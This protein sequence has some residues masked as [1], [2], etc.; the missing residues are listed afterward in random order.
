MATKAE[1]S[2]YRAERSGP[3]KPKQ[4]EPPRRDVPVDTAQPGTSATYRKARPTRT[5][6]A[7]RKG[8]AVVEESSRKSTRRSHGKVET[9]SFNEAGVESK[10]KGEGRTKRSANLQLR[11]VARVRAPSARTQ[12]KI[13]GGG[14]KLP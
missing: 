4:P 14:G 2:R 1:Q 7:S 6:K 8:G 3:K 13:G 11:T 5:I 12:R 10:R 9:S